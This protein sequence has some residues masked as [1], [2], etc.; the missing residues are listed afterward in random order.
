V[1]NLIDSGIQIQANEYIIFELSIY[2]L[3]LSKIIILQM[4]ILQLKEICNLL[5]SILIY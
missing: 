1:S 4:K 3:L 5:K 2:L